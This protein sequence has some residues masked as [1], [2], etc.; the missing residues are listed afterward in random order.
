ME[1]NFHLSY[2]F[3]VQVL[4]KR[5]PNLAVVVERLL[6][7]YCKLTGDRHQTSSNPQP[8]TYQM[9]TWSHHWKAEAS[10]WGNT[11]HY[12]R[13]F[14][15]SLLHY[16]KKYKKCTFKIINSVMIYWDVIYNVCYFTVPDH[17]MLIR[18]FSKSSGQI[19]ICAVSFKCL[20]ALTNIT[21]SR[22]DTIDLPIND[23][24]HL[25]ARHVT[26][27]ST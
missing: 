21:E 3:S 25:G 7:I 16:C 19:C 22:N 2:C 24:C 14:S 20:W 15:K 9:N 1:N 8:K 6:D 4:M 5:Y 12:M 23:E 11:F 26:N 27:G 10:H 13:T 18:T 17:F